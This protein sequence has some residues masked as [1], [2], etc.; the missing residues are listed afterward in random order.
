[1]QNSWTFLKDL[2]TFENLILNMRYVSKKKYV[3]KNLTKIKLNQLS[4]LCE[5]N[6]GAVPV[7]DQFAQMSP[8]Q[9]SQFTYSGHKFNQLP[10]RF[11]C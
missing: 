2:Q 5:S 8:S 9:L 7:L 1:M 10:L 3:N 4:T 11:K 6:A